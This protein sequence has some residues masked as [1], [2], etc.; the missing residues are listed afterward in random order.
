LSTITG[1]REKYKDRI[2]QLRNALKR[3]GESEVYELP[4]F[5]VGKVELPQKL[6]ALILSGTEAH[7]NEDLEQY[8]TE[9]ELIR[10]IHVPVLGICFG[11]QLIGKAFGSRLD[12]FDDFRTGFHSVEIL[13]PN[14]L[15]STWKEGDTVRLKQSHKDYLLEIPQG[16]EWLAKSEHCKIETMKHQTKSI[17]GI[18]AHIERADEINPD[19]LQVLRNFLNAIGKRAEFI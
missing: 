4:F 9:M 5:K 14:D 10:K 18:Q 8:R 3:L 15:F 1:I 7:L 16:F 6:E 17:Y 2:Q 19:G 13:Q 12:H 11:H